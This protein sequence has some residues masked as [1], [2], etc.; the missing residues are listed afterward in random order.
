[1]KR[2]DYDLV[3]GRLAVVK[4]WDDGAPE[5]TP[6]RRAAWDRAAR[7][8]GQRARFELRLRVEEWG[9]SVPNDLRAIS[10]PVRMQEE[11]DGAA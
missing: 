5:P 4:E 9:Y 6:E 7:A 2:A 11:A 1:M 8:W 3:D 10:G